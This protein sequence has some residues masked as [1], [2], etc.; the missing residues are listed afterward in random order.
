[1]QIATAR[2]TL[3]LFLLFGAV[4]LVGFYD[5]LPKEIWII[6]FP[7]LVAAFFLDT[8]AF[9]EFGIQGN[10]VFYLMLVVSLS[11]Q[12]VVLMAGVRL[13]RNRLEQ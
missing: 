2:E 8:L 10:V 13:F 7:A 11:L 9:N 6:D 4:W 3:A 5:V 1:M 12:A